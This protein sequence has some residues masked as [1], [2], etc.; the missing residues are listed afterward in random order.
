MFADHIIRERKDRRLPAA[1]YMVMLYATISNGILL[2]PLI[3]MIPFL[4]TFKTAYL[5]DKRVSL[6]V[7]ITS[8]IFA[9]PVASIL[10]FIAGDK[11]EKG[12]LKEL[13]PFVKAPGKKEL[14]EYVAS[15]EEVQK[16]MDTKHSTSHLI[17]KRRHVSLPQWA[18][19][20]IV[21]IPALIFIIFFMFYP[22]IN[23]FLM[24]FVNGYAYKD[25]GSSQHVRRDRETRRQHGLR[26]VRLT[27]R[28]TNDTYRLHQRT[29]R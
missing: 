21:L 16:V 22:I 27:L 24:A 11:N 15:S 6:A 17:S 29:R 8:I 2:I 19:A 20:W 26:Q 13:Q 23:T 1:A 9:S 28:C 5:E 14:K 4:R 12:E 10:M 3:W 25:G 18:T 7:K